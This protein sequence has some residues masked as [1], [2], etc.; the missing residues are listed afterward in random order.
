[1]TGSTV[2][3]LLFLIL[4]ICTQIFAQPGV[5]YYATKPERQKVSEISEVFPYTRAQPHC[6]LVKIKKTTTRS[7]LKKAGLEVV[8]E[9]GDDYTIIRSKGPM[10]YPC[11]FK[12]IS[13]VNYLWK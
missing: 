7:E 6:H 9:L 10:Q 8:R 11:L 12:H 1:M 2:R 4:G 3:I 5:K 13:P